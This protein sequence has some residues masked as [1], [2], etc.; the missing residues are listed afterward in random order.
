MKYT[1]GLDFGTLSVRAVL[2]SVETGQIVS[3]YV[4][5]YKNG[6]MDAK[7]VGGKPLPNDFALQDAIDYIESMNEVI[8]KVVK[9][10]NIDSKD[11][12]GIGVDFTASTIMPIKADG[13]PLS[14]LSKYKDNPYAYCKLWKHHSAEEYAIKITELA[15]KRDEPWIKRYGYKISSEWML[16]KVFETLD[17]AE[18]VFNDTDYF[19]EAGD[20]ITFYLTGNLK[21]SSC[22]AGYK[23]IWHDVEGYP[24]KA[25]LSELNE[26]LTDLYDTKLSGDVIPLG[27]KQ[28]LLKLEIANYLGLKQVPV[29]VA[30]IDAHVATPACQAVNSGDML[31]IIGTSSC[32]IVLSDKEITIP[33]IQG[34]VKDGAI[35]GLYAYE[36]GQPAVGDIFSWFIENHVPSEYHNHAAMNNQNIY[37]F[38]EDR[39]RSI[40][41]TKSRLLCLDWWNGNR[42]V[43]VDPDL[44][45]LIVGYNL[46]TKPEEI[47]RALIE[48]TA[49][50][51]RVTVD[52]YEKAGIKIDRLIACGGLAT[53]NKYL[54]E[55]YANILGK[56]IYFTEEEYAPA[57]G[58]AIFGALAASKGNGGYNSINEAVKK[59]SRLNETPVLPGSSFNYDKLYEMYKEL[60]DYFGK[61]SA[62]MKE[63]KV[64]K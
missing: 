40:P 55:C 41:K 12:I 11:I 6:V 16:P 42:S 63:L 64:I 23:G 29:G 17:K 49:F 1:I 22:Q 26:K 14:R 25:Y 46:Q 59:M 20:Y 27:S 43:L 57:L 45:G 56:P 37:Q 18:D 52:A 44:T 51:K 38:M 4:S 36:S 53:K 9:T 24:S 5:K 8:G 10:S 54:L 47:Y 50:G 62:L 30:V 13:T 33:G 34:V 7:L 15:I 58:A 2:V 19:I 35:P 3:S 28:G 21:R 39:I 31:M 32:D 61:K 60:H 48:A